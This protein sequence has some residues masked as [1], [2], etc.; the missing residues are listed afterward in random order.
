[1]PKRLNCDDF[2]PKWIWWIFRSKMWY[3]PRC[4]PISSSEFR[5]IHTFFCLFLKQKYSFCYRSIL[6]KSY[7][8]SL[9]R[10]VQVAHSVSTSNYKN[11]LLHPKYYTKRHWSNTTQMNP[12]CVFL[13]KR[14]YT[15]LVCFVDSSFMHTHTLNIHTWREF[16]RIGAKRWKS[17]VIVVSK[18]I[19]IVDIVLGIVFC[20][21]H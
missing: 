20:V 6:V 11:N 15:T 4:L 18:L 10:E 14:N 17:S 9:V 3:S 13:L 7:F 16:K 2:G 21:I 12:N 5:L 19:L 1:M 8:N